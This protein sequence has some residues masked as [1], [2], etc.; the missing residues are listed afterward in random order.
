ME[1]FVM[2]KKFN[3]DIVRDYTDYESNKGKFEVFKSQAQ[4]PAPISVCN[5]ARKNINFDA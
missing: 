3:E 1:K 2:R 5:K 4:L